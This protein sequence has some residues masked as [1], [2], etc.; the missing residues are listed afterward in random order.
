MIDLADIL[1]R[2]EVLVA[3]DTR[4]PPRAIAVS[5]K[6]FDFLLAEL[7]GCKVSVTDHGDGSIG[8]LAVRG[9][10]RTLFNF[11]L[12]TVP[13]T[14]GWMR[15]PFSLLVKDGRVTGLGAC[16]IK[17]A[18]ACMLAVAN[19]VTGDLAILVTTD[20]EAGA[21]V[22]VKA[23]LDSD[24][25]F[26]QVL[27]AEPT[28]C[29]AVTAHRGII[30]AR[31]VFGG[32]AGHASSARV[33]DDS[34][35]HRAVRWAGR[36]LAKAGSWAQLEQSGLQGIPLNIGRIEGGIKPNMIADR[37]EVRLG[38][39]TLPGQ[40]GEPL[41]EE[42]R[43]EAVQEEILDW[44]ITFSAPSLPAAAGKSA[45]KSSG[46]PQ[47][48]GLA[49]G[50]AVGFWSEAA[51]FS[52]AGLDAAVLGSGDIAQAHTSDEWVAVAQLQELAGIYS[53]LVVNGS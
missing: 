31:A 1:E 15:D 48:L 49:P 42:L 5:D 37:C 24:H 9:N 11:H 39:R 14:D 45:D 28:R 52:A 26:R 7:Q 25:G 4:N 46:L 34:A 19:S 36:C 8:L 40:N 38:L 17:G 32:V 35:N 16:D 44:Q 2:L 30:T 47:R 50:P 22:A 6:V 29:Q 10:P 3:S 20:E 13:D 41:M 23:F 43:G 27:V 51:L 12:D 53:R 21:G 18:L 33:L